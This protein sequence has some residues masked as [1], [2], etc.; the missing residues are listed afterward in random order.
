M[1]GHHPQ[2]QAGP[3]P[4]EARRLLWDRIWMRLLAPLSER[5]EEALT[6]S[7]V[8]THGLADEPVE[9]EGS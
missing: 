9:R 8:P 3:L 2:I 1:T 4:V 7:G 5:D 6:G